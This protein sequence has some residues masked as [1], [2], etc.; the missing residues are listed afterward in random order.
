MLF[1]APM[2]FLH[3]NALKT[4]GFPEHQNEADILEM[5]V[6]P[7]YRHTNSDLFPKSGGQLF[8]VS[9]I[10]S[11][12]IF[13]IDTRVEDEERSV[14]GASMEHNL[15]NIG[16]GI[17]WEGM[18]TKTCAIRDHAKQL[19]SKGISTP[20]I[21]IDGGD[22]L[23]GGCGE[24]ELLS[25]YYTIVA[26]C[27]GSELVFGAELGLYPRLQKFTVGYQRFHGRWESILHAANLNERS[28][29]RYIKCLPSVGP[30]PQPPLA[31][32]LNSGFIMGPPHMIHSAYEFACANLIETDGP[33]EQRYL[34]EFFLSNEDTTCLDYSSNLV[35]N[36]HQFDPE[37]TKHL[38]SFAE[39]KL[40]N[41]VAS[42]YQCFVH[43]NGNG[44]NLV[45]KIA[46]QLMDEL[47][48][49]P[50]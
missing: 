11:I 15:T 37:E 2:F 40:W 31:Q 17:R 24:S 29:A 13:E 47:P 46:R 4:H 50:R 9:Q 44:K 45:G 41:T 39:G 22:V 5:P 19:M 21:F 27:G 28:Y 3:A 43:G 12:P 8:H 18:K 30:C 32:F 49:P 38:F 14:W 6:G 48:N 26:N 34:H 36:L 42:K 33:S 10:G 20:V 23:Y 7:L 35:L 25:R 1:A 16:A